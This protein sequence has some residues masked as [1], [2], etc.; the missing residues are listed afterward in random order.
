M[1]VLKI[2]FILLF[3]QQSLFVDGQSLS[4]NKDSLGGKKLSLELLKNNLELSL[5]DSSVGWAFSIWKGNK[6]V[7]QNAGGY[8]VLASDRKD[9]I[10]LP[11]TADTRMHIASLSKSI[12]ALAVAKLA[13]M[14]KLEWEDPIKKFLPSYWKLHPG[15]ESTTIRQLVIMQSG[16]NGPLDAVTSGMDSLQRI[17]ERGP[18][19]SK[20]GKFNYQNTGYG[21][22]RIII[23]YAAGLKEYAGNIL[24]DALPAVCAEQYVRFV[25]ENIF[26]PAGILPAACRIMEN[27]P[28][29]YYPFPSG[30]AKGQLTGSGTRSGGDLSLYA[31]G[32]GWYLSLH[33]AGQLLTA[34]FYSKKILSAAVLDQLISFKFP[35]NIRQ[36]K[37]GTYFGTGG[38]WGNP[39]PGGRWAGIHTYFLC[40]PENIRVIVFMNSGE[41]SP[42]GKMMRAYRNSFR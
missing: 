42:G 38:D 2:S 17:M 22:L 26:A 25:N 21:L 6:V 41:G 28:A 13:E 12:T 8:K 16:L 36:G 39:L 34:L 1:R 4:Y 33:D 35:F 15:F 37:L 3:F 24:D 29:L 30:D 20:V 19:T 5:K 32:F 18:D 40:F 23:A 14:K 11:F 27:E 10:G 9:A 31:G 7:Y